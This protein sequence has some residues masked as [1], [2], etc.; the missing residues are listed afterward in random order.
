[1]KVQYK[2]LMSFLG[3][4]RNLN[5]YETQPWMTYSSDEDITC[6]AE[7]RCNNDRSE[8]EAEIQFMYEK[9]PQ[10]TPPVD[11]V[12]LIQAK[13]QVNLN[14]A[15][16][17]VDV[18]I[19]GE[20]YQ[21]KFHDWETKSCN[22]FRACVREIKADKIPD[23]DE[24]LKREMKGTG[25]FGANQGDGSDKSPKINTSSLMYDMKNKMGRGF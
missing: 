8:I 19:K 9:P 25:F 23:I 10:G 4:G 17:V 15:F 1:M 24:I 16:A 14:G 18:H 20:S 21:N 22:F 2:E 13:S 5:P 3:V 6:E 12:C 11:R 7:V